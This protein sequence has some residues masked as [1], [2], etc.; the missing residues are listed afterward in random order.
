[1]I[2]G[3]H[4]RSDPRCTCRCTSLFA[5]LHF[6]IPSP[7]TP[8]AASICNPKIQRISGG[9]PA[10]QGKERTGEEELVEEVTENDVEE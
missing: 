9:T 1:M 7:D 4:A 3:G 8:L 6:V 2:S 5:K 10:A